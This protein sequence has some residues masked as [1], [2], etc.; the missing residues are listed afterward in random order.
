MLYTGV[1][2]IV[3]NLFISFFC[4]KNPYAWTKAANMAFFS[5]TRSTYSLGWLLIAFYIILGHTT[6]GKFA[7]CNPAFNAMGKIVYITYLISPVVMMII[8]SNTDHGVF[9][10][11]VGNITLGMGHMMLAFVVGFMIYAFF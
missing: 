1:I 3:I 10:T 4:T 9:M 8:Y 6:V 2:L 5:L 11:L 7:L